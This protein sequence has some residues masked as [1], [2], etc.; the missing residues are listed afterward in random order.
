MTDKQVRRF[1]E[2]NGYPAHLVRGGKK[3]LLKRW[4]DFVGE[5]ESGYQLGLEDY[6]NDLDVRGILALA[7]LHGEVTEEDGRFR[8]MLTSTGTRVWESSVPEGH[9][10]FW[11]FGYPK[12]AKGGLLA[13]LRAEGLAK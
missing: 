8:A 7:G 11:D 6:R 4:R 2:D 9:T 5:V 3:G 10:A 1:L 12:N 13:D